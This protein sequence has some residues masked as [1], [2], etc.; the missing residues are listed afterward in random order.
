MNF[1]SL[2]HII[3]ALLL[4]T[5]ALTGASGPAGWAAVEGHGVKTTSGGGDVVAVTVTTLEELNRL[6]S[7]EEPQVI[8]ISGKISTGP[9]AVRIR[10]NKTLRGTDKDA[11]IHG[12]LDI[13]DA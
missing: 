3:L 13:R 1:P 7:L 2:I 11:T 6:V 4:S 10:S 9:R 5:P 8:L 12:G